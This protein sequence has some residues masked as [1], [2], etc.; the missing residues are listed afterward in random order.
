MSRS[1]AWAGETAKPGDHGSAP[2]YEL[3][4][5]RTKHYFLILPYSVLT[6]I[7][8]VQERRDDIEQVA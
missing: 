1:S 4:P 3:G 7:G 5:R 2:Q 8:R 6:L